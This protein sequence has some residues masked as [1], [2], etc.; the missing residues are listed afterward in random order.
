MRYMTSALSA[1]IAVALGSYA[2]IATESRYLG[3]FL[4][5]FGMLVVCIFQLPLYTG[6]IS[7]VGK[8]GPRPR[9]F[10]TMLPMNILGAVLVGLLSYPV[11]GG[12][13]VQLIVQDKLNQPFLQNFM[14]AM[15][16]GAV[17]FCIVHIFRHSKDPVGRYLGILLGVPVFVISRM[18]NSIPDV[19]YVTAALKQY[20]YFELRSLPFLLTVLVGNG[21]GGWLL[22]AIMP[23]DSGS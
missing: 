6:R 17:I 16:C 19:F 23:R 11:K 3:G 18:E 21:L 14:T 1:G 8:G 2:Y 9:D 10:L 12:A 22:H 4:F 15:L 13:D 7:Y 5:S 20:G